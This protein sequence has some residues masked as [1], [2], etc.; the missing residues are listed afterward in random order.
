MLVDAGLV[1]EFWGY[2]VLVATHILNRMPSRAHGNKS[3]VEE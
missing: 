3:Y 1:N 2:I